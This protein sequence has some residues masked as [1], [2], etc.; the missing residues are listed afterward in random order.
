[1]GACETKYQR[2]VRE[3][4]KQLKMKIFNK[5]KLLENGFNES[6]PE[7]IVEIF[8]LLEIYPES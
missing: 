4:K 7:H 8:L 5:V 6:N 3:Q 2:E 1:M